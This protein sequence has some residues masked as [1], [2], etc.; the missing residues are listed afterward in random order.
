[1]SDQQVRTAIT[2]DAS[3]ANREW[4]GWASQV[5][6]ASGAVKG[7]LAG[8]ASSTKAMQGQIKGDLDRVAGAIGAVQ[9]KF[10]MWAAL[11]A[12]GAGLKSSI[13]ATVGFTLESAALGRALGT[14]AGEAAKWNIALGDVYSSS[15]AAIAA[16]GKLAK[17][18]R[19][20][21][22]D[23]NALG[24][25]TRDASGNFRSMNEMLMDAIGIA[26]SYAEGT[27]R[28]MALQVLF[29]KGSEE[30]TALLKLNN[31][32]LDAAATKQRELGLIV[33]SEN[34]DATTRYRAA[35][36]D[37]GDVLLALRKA[38][39]DA[40]LPVLAK[41]GEWMAAA[42]P[43]ALAVTRFAVNSLVV[44]FWGL[45]NAITIVW[46]VLDSMV[47]TMAEPLHALSLSLAKLLT[48]DFKGA[49]DALLAMPDRIKARWV[50]ATESMM[51][52]SQE[53]RDRIFE[54]FSDQ[55]QTRP[56]AGG[57]AFVGDGG[58]K[59]KK[60]KEDPSMMAHYEAA[61]EQERLAATQRDA[62]RGM[63]KEAEAAFW[64][65]L[66]ADAATSAKDRQAIQAK[67]TKLEVE[68]LRDAA[69]QARQISDI[70][71]GDMRDA[72]LARIDLDAEAARTQVALG[73][74]T[75]GQLLQQ[76]L[77]FEDARAAIKRAAVAARLAVLDPDKDAVAVAQL[78]AQLQAQE[79][80]HQ[81][82]MAAIRG[83]I[84]VQSA[85]ETNAVWEDAASRTSGLWDKG[86]QAMMNGTF[87]W[88]NATKAV[89]AE[90]AGW[91]AG[92]VK[93]QVATW[94][95][96]EQAKTGATAAGTAARW[97]METWAAAKSV[98]LWAATAVKNIMTSAWEAMAAAWKAVVG[99]PYVGPV[100]AVAAAAAAFAGVSALASNVSAAG[101]YDI[102]AGVNPMVQTHA[103][104]MIL[105]ATLANT[106]RDMASVYTQ[107][108][109]GQGG[110]GGGQL[111]VQ[112]RGASAGDFFLM[113]KADLVK[114]LR[115]A[116][117]DMD[118]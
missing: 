6:A 54:L 42:G 76:E 111:Q 46:E 49:A 116:R 63:S 16:A 94:V 5:Q 39:G 28:T 8:I 22:E 84:A 56:A 95:F 45:K 86:V 80:E 13:D 64:R 61:L 26:N 50:A 34:V 110:G 66:A 53:A 20:N 35:V 113:H 106:V 115:A 29:G 43:A 108:R 40:V 114:A 37:V 107:A 90:L 72:A 58:K 101:G 51:D 12:G 105:P 3:Q 78:N 79:R 87:T 83:Q 59:E 104:E 89:G 24:L 75:Q 57:K 27:D 14:T 21:E 52:S 100:L 10:A 36:N 85:A 19:T 25:A 118:F 92:I 62:L 60:A 33:G 77:Q 4:A 97:A 98:A 68:I 18:V 109:A 65:G 11:L 70:T 81:Q 47:F 55:G 82:K 74:A 2:A 103:Q 88:R 91:F 30:T 48:G 41:L 7:S 32:V 17:Q 69:K 71:L 9:S 67:I 112:L 38:T 73:N 117:R 1:M 15:E 44:S 93:R 31:E 99:I 102:P 23:I 96:G